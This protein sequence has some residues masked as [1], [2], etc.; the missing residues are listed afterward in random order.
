MKQR[1]ILPPGCVSFNDGCRLLGFSPATGE[2]RMRTPTVPALP[3]VHRLGVR[4]RYFKLDEL[5][6]FKQSGIASEVMAMLLRN[7][8]HGE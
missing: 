4:G 2:R 3:P 6:A 5:V 1:P 7:S 8:S